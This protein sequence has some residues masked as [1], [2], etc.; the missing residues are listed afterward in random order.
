MGLYA[1]L[2]NK[3]RTFLAWA[4]WRAY[5][6]VP[7]RKSDG[8][9]DRLVGVARAIWNGTAIGVGGTPACLPVRLDAFVEGVVGFVQLA[10][11]SG[12]LTQVFPEARHQTLKNMQHHSSFPNGAPWHPPISEDIPAQ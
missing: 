11:H 2:N 4:G 5:R 1:H 10:H 12:L 3:P 7:E 8:I 6:D 9:D